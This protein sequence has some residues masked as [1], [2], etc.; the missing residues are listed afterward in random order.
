MSDEDKRYVFVIGQGAVIAFMAWLLLIRFAVYVE[1]Q[2][3]IAPPPTHTNS[4]HRGM[5]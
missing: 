5:N 3:P 2:K 1:S 4:F